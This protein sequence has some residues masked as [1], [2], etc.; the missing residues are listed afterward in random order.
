MAIQLYSAFYSFAMGAIPFVIMA[1]IFPINMKGLA[2]PLLLIVNALCSLITTYTFLFAMDWSSAGVFL[3]FCGFCGGGLL[4]VEK[5]V[6]ETKCRTL[7]E[8]QESMVHF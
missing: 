2:G 1:E 5:L 8:I 4:F 7:E 3:I 6:P